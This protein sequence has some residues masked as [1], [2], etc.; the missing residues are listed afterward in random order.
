MN[1]QWSIQFNPPCTRFP[2]CQSRSCTDYTVHIDHPIH[3]RSLA[4]NASL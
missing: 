3:Q 1:N 2:Q 4:R